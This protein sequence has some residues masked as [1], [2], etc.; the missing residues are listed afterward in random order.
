MKIY[1]TVTLCNR[2]DTLHTSAA[3]ETQ[4]LPTA[5]KPTDAFPWLPVHTGEEEAGDGRVLL[6]YK[7]KL[8]SIWFKPLV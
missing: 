4:R 5:F 2:E 1:I 6:F 7:Y 3:D 8:V